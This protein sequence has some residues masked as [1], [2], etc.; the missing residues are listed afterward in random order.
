MAPQAQAVSNET[1]PIPAF[2]NC[3]WGLQVWRGTAQA[4]KHMQEDIKEANKVCMCHT[5]T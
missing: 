2:L 4:L 1:S 3:H 5:M